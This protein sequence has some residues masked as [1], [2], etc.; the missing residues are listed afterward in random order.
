M[1]GMLFYNKNLSVMENTYELL[2]DVY[3]DHD[4]WK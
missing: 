3:E 1:A 2:H 4:K